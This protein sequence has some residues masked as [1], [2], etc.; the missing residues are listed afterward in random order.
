MRL[1]Q[2]AVPELTLEF[3]SHKGFRRCQAASARQAYP[4][5]GVTVLILCGI[6]ALVLLY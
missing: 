3:S 1:L 4:A 6:T 2:P 5:I